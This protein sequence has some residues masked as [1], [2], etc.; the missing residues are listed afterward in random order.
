MNHP[1]PTDHP[2]RVLLVDDHRTALW[3]LARLVQGEAPRLSLVGIATDAEQALHAARSRAP[4]VVLLDGHLGA[5][6]GLLEALRELGPRVVV[7]VAS[8]DAARPRRADAVLPKAG[9]AA[10]ILA[11]IDALA[12]SAR[13]TRAH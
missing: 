4:D 10:R 13:A 9:P 12:A 2:T 1:S 7:L 6:P 5:E 8:A 3:G 11:A